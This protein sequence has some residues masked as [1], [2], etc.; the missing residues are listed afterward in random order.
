M[1]VTYLTGVELKDASSDIKTAYQ[2]RGSTHP[3]SMFTGACSIGE[4]AYCTSTYVGQYKIGYYRT[5][6]AKTAE[7]GHYGLPRFNDT[8][9]WEFIGENFVIP[10]GMIKVNTIN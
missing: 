4:I 10:Y 2:F 1:E 6:Q 9:F 3:N 7:E 8:D 5:L